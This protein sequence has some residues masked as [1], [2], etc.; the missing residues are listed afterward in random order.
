MRTFICLELPEMIRAQ[1]EG[2]QRRL[3]GLGDKI[4]WGEPEGICT[5]HCGSW[6]RFHGLKSRLFAS[7][8]VVLPRAWMRSPF[9]FP[10]QLFPI[11]PTPQRI[12]D[13][14]GRCVAP[15]SSV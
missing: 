13:W 2:L 6:A 10:E 11:L 9:A 1:A 14:S 15:G 4:R 3:A 8:C 5:S 12:L 7:P